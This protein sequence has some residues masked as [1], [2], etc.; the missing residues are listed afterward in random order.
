[1]R[2]FYSS[3]LALTLG[4]L[5][6]QAQLAH[7]QLA[8]P[9]SHSAADNA[10]YQ[11]PR[12]AASQAE[13]RGTPWYTEDFSGGTIPAGW[14]NVDDLTPM[15]DPNVLWVWSNDPAAV[16]VAALGY[17]PSSIFGATT[18][19][20]GYLWCNSD[21][22]LAAA[23][24]SDHHTVLTS[25]AIDCS[26]QP[27]VQLS[28][29]SLIGV[30]DYD[31]ADNVKLRVST[32][33]VNWTDYVPFPCLVTGA[34]SPPCTRW[35]ANPQTVELDISAVAANQP[36]VYLQWEWLG[37]WEYFWAIDDIQLAPLPQYERVLISSYVSHAGDGFEFGRI[38]RTQLPTDFI[39]GA[40]ARN[41]GANPQTNLVLTVD[42]MDPG[43]NPSFSATQTFASVLPGDTATMEELVTL[44]GSLAE[45]LYSVDVRVS[46]DQDVDE[47]NPDNDTVA[48]AFELD[49]YLYGLDGI[50]VSPGTPVLTSTGSNSFGDSTVSLDD[51]LMLFTFF[52]ISAPT[53]IYGLEAA[54]ATGTVE[55]GQAVFTI[56]TY[57]DINAT[58]EMGNTWPERQHHRE[59]Y[60]PHERHI[61]WSLLPTG[62]TGCG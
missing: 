58:P 62:P 19:A 46:S 22:G 38:P 10:A 29:Q 25:T 20:N 53:T 17:T 16:G 47:G 11:A 60:G 30:F 13:E 37:G 55:G 31:A 33:M 61:A 7:P 49:D 50:G 12:P 45:G 9:K 21:R 15:G 51:G 52:R 4:S 5:A 2:K 57:D 48:R 27:S 6:A 35:S 28:F 56:H 34:A 14:T 39:L 42:V 41:S 8:L 40:A 3:A 44:P 18:P 36:T 26:G 54:L 24:A 43:G 59:R 32:D 1:M 23:P